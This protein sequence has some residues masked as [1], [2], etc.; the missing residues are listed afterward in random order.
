MK[1]D[2]A[3]RLAI[4]GGGTGGHVVPGLHMLGELLGASDLP[5]LT[6]LVWFETGRAAEGAALSRLDALI[7]PLVPERCRLT[8]EP[9]SGGAPSLMRLA[10]LAPREV[11]RARRVLKRHQTD[12]VFGLGGFTL[13]PV[14]LAARSLGIPVVLLEINAVPGRAVVKLTPFAT[15]VLH[16]WPRTMVPGDKH[17]LTGP[18]LGP[19]LTRSAP[20]PTN[21]WRTHLNVAAD[22]PLLAVI[23]GS[24]GALCLNTF[25]RTH[26]AALVAQGVAIVHQVG[27]GRLEEAA[28]AQAG[29]LALEFVED[30]VALLSEATV[31]L[32]R[33]GASTLA[34]LAVLGVPSLVVPFSGAGGH[35]RINAQELG[36]AI[37]VVEEPELAADG[38]A[39]LS[40]R[41]GPAGREWRAAARVDLMAR[42]PRDAAR[43]VATELARFAKKK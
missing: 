37:R 16:A 14:V 28:T 11:L 21:Q 39:L 12:V 35:Q 6:D 31:A 30:M 41:L 38:L 27:P 17:V 5:D 29:Y 43:K 32:T 22:A 10:T 3:L 23:G 4:V 36:D 15:R 1:T 19:A 33:A 40:E 20:A 9:A 2:R 24:Q 25:V 34:E 8:L 42:V 7:A 26:A 18:P 13:L